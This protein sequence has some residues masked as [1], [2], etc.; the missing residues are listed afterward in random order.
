MPTTLV[1]M[2]NF[3]NTRKPTM[4]GIVSTPIDIPLS[5]L[6]PIKLRIR[7]FHFLRIRSRHE[8][9]KLG[10]QTAISKTLK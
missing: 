1:S 4:I 8:L 10:I 5:S 6:M 2:W 7:V 3:K 9:K